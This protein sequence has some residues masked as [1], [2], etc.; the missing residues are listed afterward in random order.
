MKIHL[1]IGSILLSASLPLCHAADAM[2]PTMPGV[3]QGQAFTQTDGAALYEAICQACH[4]PAGAGGSGAGSYP[5][6]AR[7]THLKAKVY[8]ITK[9][10]YGSKAM[11]P[12][13][14][15]LS[16]EQIA[17]V[18]GYVRTHFGNRYTDRISPADVKALRQ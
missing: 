9:V 8:P 18:V 12:F 10:L 15:Q 17:A 14:G 5:A 13:K 11:P 3:G 6:L 2:K 1:L 7:N 4:M 16:D